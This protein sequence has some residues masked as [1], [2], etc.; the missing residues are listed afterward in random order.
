MEWSQS[1][2]SGGWRVFQNLVIKFRTPPVSVE[3]GFVPPPKKKMIKCFVPPP[4]PQ[5]KIKK[6]TVYKYLDLRYIYA[7]T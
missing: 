4:P 5:L 1:M 3:E 7:E 6:K 2:C